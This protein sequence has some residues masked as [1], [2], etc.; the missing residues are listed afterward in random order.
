MTHVINTGALL[1][2][3]ALAMLA[4]GWFGGGPAAS[5]AQAIPLTS[6]LTVRRDDQGVVTHLIGADGVAV[7][8]LPIQR[9]ASVSLV[10]DAALLELCEPQRV[11]AWS[12]YTKEG[13]RARRLGAHPRLKGISDLEAITALKPD[14]VLVSTYGGESDRLARLRQAGLTVF[15]MGPMTGPESYA[16]DAERIGLLLGRQDEG[17]AVGATLLQRLNRVAADL[18]ADAVRPRAMYVARIGDVMF[19]G[20]KGTSYHEVITKGGCR[21]AAAERYAG[22]PQLSVEELLSIAPELILT[23]EGNG[24][25]LRRLPGFDRLVNVRF[26]ELPGWL[27]EDP[28]PGTLEAAEA[29]FKAVHGAPP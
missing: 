27:L 13:P 14:L 9:I 15:A 24:D 25:E 5:R 23:R 16:L 21:D 18:P 8:L 11:V 7:A 1:L 29:L 10:A 19:G 6:E 22:W 2:A 12:A 28:G 17:R 26:V 20:T 3:I 4:V